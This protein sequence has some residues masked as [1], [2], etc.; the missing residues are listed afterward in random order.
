MD[1]AHLRSPRRH[2]RRTKS[3]DVTKGLHSLPCSRISP[4]RH[5]YLSWGER[6]PAQHGHVRR[7]MTTGLAGHRPQ[8]GSPTVGGPAA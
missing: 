7:S 3:F 4:R 8:G 1:R 5:Q 2:G 6:L